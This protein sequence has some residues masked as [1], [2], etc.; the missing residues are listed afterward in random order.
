M[1]I[2]QIEPLELVTYILIGLIGIAVIGFILGYV[3]TLSIG[4]ADMTLR[5][6]P[7][8]GKAFV[9]RFGSP[10]DRSFE[11]NWGLDSSS[12]CSVNE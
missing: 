3:L 12:A 11:L 4:L 6:L 2:P 7:S 10:V 9:N 8:L 1:I 5:A